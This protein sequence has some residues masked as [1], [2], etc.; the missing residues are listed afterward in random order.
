[1]PHAV[2]DHVVNRGFEPFGH[3]GL[4]HMAFDGNLDPGHGRDLA[5][6]ACGDD[7]DL[8]GPDR[9]ARGLHAFD[10]TA[11]NVD[12][13]DF[14]VLDQVHS[15]TVRAARISPGDRVMARRAATPMHQ[16]AIDREPGVVEIKIG[17]FGAHLLC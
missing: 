9:P 4:Q 5:R 12:P 17:N 11:H 15:K 2:A 16:A 1:M 3:E 13:C 10:N 7:A 8:L 6:A 14:A